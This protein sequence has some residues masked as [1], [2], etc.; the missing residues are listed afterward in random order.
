MNIREQIE[1]EITD[2]VMTKLASERVELANIKTIISEYRQINSSA[3]NA[4]GFI[5][6]A[7]QT[8]NKSLKSMQ[9]LK[10]EMARSANL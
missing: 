4:G 9:G 5:L 1:K 10:K 6:K 2:K 3:S 7:K 8:L